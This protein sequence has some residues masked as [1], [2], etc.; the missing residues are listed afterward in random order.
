MELIRLKFQKKVGVSG[1]VISIEP[2][3][4]YL[5]IQHANLKSHGIKNVHT[6]RAAVADKRGYSYLSPPEDR[7]EAYVMGASGT[8]EGT[9]LIRIDDFEWDTQVDG[10]FVD[11]EGAENFFLEGARQTILRDRPL[12]IMNLNDEKLQRYGTHR[13]RVFDVIAEHF[14]EVC[15]I[16][17]K[18]SETILAIPREKTSYF[19]QSGN[20][21]SVTDSGSARWI[22]NCKIPLKEIKTEEKEITMTT[23]LQSEQNQTKFYMISSDDLNKINLKQYD[24][25]IDEY[26]K[27][28]FHLEAGK[29][30]YRLLAHFS[31]LFPHR[32][33]VDV[34]TN[35]GGSAIALSHDERTQVVTFDIVN[36]RTIPIQKKNVEFRLKD[37]REDLNTLMSAPLIFLDTFHD[38]TFE[39]EFYQFLLEHGYKGML[40]LDDIFLNDEMKSFW[41]DIKIP[42][43]DLTAVGHWSGTGI[44]YF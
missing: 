40:L 43:A 17:Q 30:H 2:Q 26:T 20:I 41:N 37:C 44:V 3:S 35:R 16:D 23:P 39:R 19:E 29:E 13:R 8:G 11:A 31:T 34:G 38:G 15:F 33:I 14:Y 4:V 12:M 42:K 32:T 5:C 1:S 27:E 28:W 9:D 21:Q 36:N 10:I 18:N 7:M 6:M 25:L 24:H 22:F